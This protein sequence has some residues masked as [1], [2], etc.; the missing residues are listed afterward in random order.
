MKHLEQWSPGRQTATATDVLVLTGKVHHAA[1]VVWQGRCFVR[2]LLQLSGVHLNGEELTRGG[3]ACRGDKDEGRSGTHIPVE[4]AYGEQ[5]DVEVVFS[6]KAKKGEKI[7]GALLQACQA[8]TSDKWLSV[9]SYKTVVGLCIDTGVFWRFYIILS[10]IRSRTRCA[11]ISK[12]ILRKLENVV[13]V[14]KQHKGCCL[15]EGP[16]VMNWWTS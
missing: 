14:D 13:R 3:R 9:A 5:G 1:R 7:S 11:I 8:D 16:L 6:R 15:R 10:R 4:I 12:Y 2:R